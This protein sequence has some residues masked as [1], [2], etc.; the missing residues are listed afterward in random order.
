M[1]EVCWVDKDRFKELVEGGSV[2]TTFTSHRA[3][4]DDVP[5]YA[6]PQSIPLWHPIETAPRD[7]E[8]LLYLARFDEKGKLAELD[9]DGVWEYW[10]ESWELPHINGYTWMSNNG[11][12]EPTHWAYQDEPLPTSK[13][14]T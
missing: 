3:F 5:L 11:I 13:E 8:R 2:T 9:F 10:Q 1:N 7:N 6:K 14:N 4:A 12:E